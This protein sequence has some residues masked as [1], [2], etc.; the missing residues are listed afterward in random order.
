MWVGSTTDAV[1]KQLV[2]YNTLRRQLLARGTGLFTS[3]DSEIIAQMLACPLQV[4]PTNPLIDPAL[5]DSVPQHPEAHTVWPAATQS[6]ARLFKSA[7][8]AASSATK[9]VPSSPV[10]SVKASASDAARMSDEEIRRTVSPLTVPRTTSPV[11]PTR[12]KPAASRVV[13]S[14]KSPIQLEYE[15]TTASPPTLENRIAA[16]MQHAE[17]AYAFVVL[18]RDAIYGVRDPVGLR[19][20]I[21]GT[22]KCELLCAIYGCGALECMHPPVLVPTMCVSTPCSPPMA[23]HDHNRCWLICSGEHKDPDTGKQSYAVA[24]ESCALATIGFDPVRIEG[25]LLQHRSRGI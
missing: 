12:E 1:P 3:T 10:R 9:D 25:F 13:D 18:T 14:A 15:T 8:S 24:S 17:G 6:P 5:V 11:T 19:P 16:F 22:S 21:I 20:L 2:R 4:A 7:E 23:T